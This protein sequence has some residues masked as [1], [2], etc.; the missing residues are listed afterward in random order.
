MKKILIVSNSAVGLYNFRRELL[1]ELIDNGYDVL[2]AVPKVER[3]LD[4]ESMGC[5]F[6]EVKMNRRGMNIFQD[7]SLYKKYK[8]I[9]KEQ[10]PDIVVTYTIKPNIYACRAAKKMKIPYAA[11][12]TGIG[13]MFQKSITKKISVML[14]KSSLKKCN[15]VFFQNEDNKNLFIKNKIIDE[16]KVCMINGSGVNLEQFQIKDLPTEDKLIFVGRIMK[17]KG[18]DEFLYAAKKCKEN[19]LSIDFTVL[20]SF[21]DSYKEKIMEYVNNGFINYLEP[22][23][24]IIPIVSQCNCV[25]LPSYHEGMS[26]TLLEGASLG[27]PLI[28]SNIAGCKETLVN[29]KTGFLVTPKCKEDLY[30]KIVDFHNLSYEEKVLMGINGRKHVEQNFDRSLVVKKIKNKLEE[31]L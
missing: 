8:K 11:N 20:G 25:V 4:L 30:L 6:I 31:I 2:V 16:S 23:K 19:N 1:K 29:N 7:Y 27:R 18:I 17:D 26:N 13:G 22:V 9:M 21:L 10:N 14:Y 12:I 28:A 15:T 24:N 5:T 3:V